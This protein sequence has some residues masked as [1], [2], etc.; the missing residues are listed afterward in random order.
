MTGAVDDR[1][2]RGLRRAALVLACAFTALGGTFIAAEAVSDPGGATGVAL[3]ALWAVP[4]A[5]LA[6]L[7]W[8]RP[9]RAAVVLAGLTAAAVA[10]SVW[11]AVDPGSWRAFEDDHGPLRAI[12]AFVLVL[13]LALL[14]RRRPRL[15]GW[16]LL[17]VGLVPTLVAVAGRPQGSG[18]MRAVALPALVIGILHLM[19]AAAAGPAVTPPGRRR[20]AGSG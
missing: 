2:G 4:L 20:P 18:S 1:D 5:G 15:A 13:P 12:G 10:A 19:D 6:L 8:H 7:A 3:I 16:C 11:F 14:G 9:E 17:G